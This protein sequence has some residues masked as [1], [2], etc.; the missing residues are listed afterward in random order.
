M[1][2]DAVLGPSEVGVQDAHAAHENRHLR[3]GQRQKLR[4]INQHFLCPDGIVGFQIVSEPVCSRFEYGEG[5]HVGLLLR[6]IHTPRREGNR[7]LATGILRSLL[8]ASA[9]GQNDQVS[10]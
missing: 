1:G 6:R 3:S 9:T 8:H 5:L 4:T 10:E 7:H 2:E